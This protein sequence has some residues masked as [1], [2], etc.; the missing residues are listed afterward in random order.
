[1]TEPL[2]IGSDHDISMVHDDD[3]DDY[4]DIYMGDDDSDINDSDE[5]NIISR[6]IW[7]V[8]RIKHGMGGFK[9]D[10]DSRKIFTDVFHD[11]YEYKTPF[12][13][14]YK[15]EQKN[16]YYMMMEVLQRNP[17]LSVIGGMTL[18]GEQIAK[19]IIEKQKQANQ[20]QK[21]QKEKKTQI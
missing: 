1:M 3:D 14:E 18:A 16:V 15:Y 11:R 9:W 13:K 6:R 8:A 5:N 17:L 19:L 20:E 2:Y 10:T 21:K 12:D 7:I 4:A